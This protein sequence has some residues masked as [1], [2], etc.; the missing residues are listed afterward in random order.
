[1]KSCVHVPVSV[2]GLVQDLQSD[3]P[4]SATSCDWKV[5]HQVHPADQEYVPYATAWNE[6]RHACMPQ[7]LSRLVVYNHATL[8]SCCSQLRPKCNQ[9]AA[10]SDA[11]L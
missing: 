1:M 8:A 6:M 7:L 5:W 2:Q 11:A 9:A 4:H 10:V 3:A